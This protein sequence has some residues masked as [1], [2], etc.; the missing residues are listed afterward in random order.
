MPSFASYRAVG[1]VFGD[2]LKSVFFSTRDRLAVNAF[3]CNSDSMYSCCVVLAALSEVSLR[4][5]FLSVVD[6]AR[7]SEVRC[8]MDTRAIN[9]RASRMVENRES[10]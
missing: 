9:S 5:R 10:H 4:I 1:F 3:G 2:M 8:R 7:E 6:Q